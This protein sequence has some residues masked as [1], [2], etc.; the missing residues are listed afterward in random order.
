MSNHDLV[1]GLCAVSAH[2]RESRR[3]HL[4][5]FGTLIPHVFMG[6]VLAHVGTRY[7]GCGSTAEASEVQAILAVLE[8]GLAFGGRET[9]NVIALSFVADG[10]LEAFFVPLSESFGPRLRAQIASR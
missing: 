3:V 2:L 5:H 9:R 7:D 8:E 1:E 4:K 6:D 10:Q